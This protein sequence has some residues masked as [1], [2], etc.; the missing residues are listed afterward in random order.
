MTEQLDHRI[1][2]LVTKAQD[3]EQA[4]QEVTKLGDK[5]DQVFTEREI[6]RDMVLKEI[7]ENYAQIGE[8]KQT[9]DKLTAL[10]EKQEAML[11]RLKAV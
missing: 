11:T 9:R 3:I 1:Q 10:A 6:E 5:I 7:R 8:L 2:Q 4:R